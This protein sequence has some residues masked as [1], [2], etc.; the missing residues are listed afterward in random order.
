[1]Y[2]TAAATPV[3]LNLGSSGDTVSMLSNNESLADIAGNVT[4]N[5]QGGADS[6]SV[7]DQGNSAAGTYTITDSTIQRT[8]SAVISYRQVP[9]IT[10][11]GGNSAGPLT[12]NIE[13]SAAGSMLSLYPYPNGPTTFNVSPTAKN[14]ASIAGDMLVYGG[15]LVNI[16]D[17]ANPLHSTYTLNG[18]SISRSGSATIN[19][20]PGTSL[21]VNGGSG[22][23]TYDVLP[24]LYAAPLPTTLNTGPGNDTVDLAAS[25]PVTVNGQG[26]SDTLNLT[27]LPGTITS[28]AVG[29]DVK[30]RGIAEINISTNGPGNAIEVEST[31]PGTV[32][33]IAVAGIAGAGSDN[34]TIGA[35]DP[36]LG[37][38]QG[39]VIVNDEGDDLV[40]SSISAAGNV[41]LSCTGT[42]YVDGPIADSAGYTLNAILVDA[43]GV[44]TAGGT[45][46]G[47]L[48]NEGLIDLGLGGT[49]LTVN[50]DYSQAA[51]GALLVHLLGAARFGQLSVSGAASLDGTLT[52][53]ADN[54]F[55]PVRGEQFTIL[56]YGSVSGDFA[57]QNLSLGDG[58]DLY[59]S[60]GASAL[61][62][63]V[64]QSV[65]LGLSSP[66]ITYG[67]VSTTISGQLQVNGG[68]EAAP[69]GE[70]VQ[71][72]LNGVMQDATIA[73][74]G[75]FNARFATAALGVVASPY[76]ISFSY[77]GDAT[78][79]SA[80]GTSTL[81]VEPAPLTITPT[82]GQSMVYGS[83]MPFLTYAASGF[84]NGDSASLLTGLLATTATS[85]SP[86]GTYPFTLGSLAA[87]ANYTL[88]LSANPPTFAV[89]PAS[90]LTLSPA[91]LIPGAVH[92][93]YGPVTFSANG[94]VGPYTFA[95]AKGSTLPSGLRLSNGVLSGT[96]IIAGVFSFTITAKDTTDLSRT[97]S[98]RYSL[99]VNKAIA[100]SSAALPVATVGDAFQTQL[101]ATGGSGHGYTFTGTGLP[102]WLTLSPTGLLS[103]TP[104]SAL[105]SPVRFTVAVSDSNGS[106]ASRSYKL[107]LDPALTISPP[108]LSVATVGDKFSVQLRAIGGSGTG[109]AFSAAGLPSWLKLSANGLLSGTPTSAA[110]SPVSFTI[111]VRDSIKATGSA[112]YTLTI[113]PALTVSPTT[114][115]A[116]MVGQRFS[117]QLTASGGSGT[118][119]TFAAT[120]LPSW[121]KLS[122]TGLLNG[123]PP[124]GAGS[125][126]KF[127]ITVTDGNKGTASQPYVLTVG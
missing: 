64:S 76:K 92:S 80:A 16:D 22:T 81:T 70:T 58:E 44:L 40:A 8:G 63:T 108:V 32:L 103:G 54:G 78:F 46:N 127:I 13:S 68:Q 55:T 79:S 19:F 126:F 122:I 29:P 113:D 98:L 33:S 5:G 100:L 20:N 41:Q 87:G 12:Y 89:T 21:V 14:L 23:N 101:V 9:N 52:A 115:P 93:S 50:G 67:S 97:G 24:P 47:D 90:S 116:A 49:S 112:S 96:P 60:F 57:T 120:G 45:I 99:V 106:A 11:F 34:V 2:S 95:L 88:S 56:T 26:G 123:T 82:A 119:Y 17:Q 118:G 65:L 85:T 66:V 53:L 77:A 10:L 73:G 83:T 75:S 51:S 102:S 1:V 109:Y 43:K 74:D 37:S 3:T 4:I 91:T 86:V 6:L 107:K 62:L 94:G 28:S 121:L 39:T 111:T 124:T 72:T 7:Y 35:S 42:L 104:P 27:G 30:Y 61:T 18:L 25:V 114:L 125:L 110:G 69:A 38:V 117:T 15:A 59:P 36:S 48:N 84:V 105:G 31:A 71:V